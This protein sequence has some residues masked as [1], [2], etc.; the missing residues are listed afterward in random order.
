MTMYPVLRNMNNWL[1]NAFDD[2]MFNGCWMPKMNFT[3]SAINVKENENEYDV[4]LAAPGATKEDFKV[5][6]DNDGN[7]VIKMEHKSEKNNN[8]GKKEHYLRREFSYSNYEQ[9]LSLPE[10]VDRNAINAKVEN[11]VLHVV[12]PRTKK[13][14]KETKRIEVA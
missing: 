3:A 14:E 1:N 6:V 4:E 2:D 11:G 10:D 8:E 12:L 13:P 9:A 5:N 7:L